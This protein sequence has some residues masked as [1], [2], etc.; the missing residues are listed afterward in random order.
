MPTSKDFT[1]TCALSNLY[2]W[3]N[4]MIS[5]VIWDKSAQVNFLKTNKIARARR[6]SAI[7]GLWK[8]YECWFIP[9]CPRKIMWLL[10]NNVLAK[11]GIAFPLLRVTVCH[12]SLFPPTNDN[13]VTSTKIGQNFDRWIL[14]V[15]T[16]QLEICFPKTEAFCHFTF[17]TFHVFPLPSRKE[18][19]LLARLL[20]I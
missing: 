12:R 2:L 18:K 11:I 6:A 15:K 9:N 13:L 5:S 1:Y 10:V 4:R 14:M 3:G 7:C 20:F 17:L 16:H 19:Q 8:I